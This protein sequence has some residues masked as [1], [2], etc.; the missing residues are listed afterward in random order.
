MDAAKAA[1]P[2]WAALSPNARGRYLAKIADLIVEAN[3]EIAIL[4][5]ESM[6]RPI[7]LYSDGIVGANYFRYF[8]E[9]AYP[10]GNSSMNTPGFINMEIMQPVGVVAAIIP[11]NAPLVFFCK[12]A[13]AAMAAGN[14]VIIKSS[15]KA[16]LTVS[17][18]STI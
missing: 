16:P 6:G 14:C 11:W 15:E 18:M 12:K 4:E 10:Q 9:A 13:A 5:A 7:S 8:S 3:D 2:A 1:F 17:R